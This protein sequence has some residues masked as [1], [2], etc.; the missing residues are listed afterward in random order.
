MTTN[1]CLDQIRKRRPQAEEGELASLAAAGHSPEEQFEESEKQGRLARL[2]ARL[3]ERER[4]CLMLRDLE[5][6][7]SREVE[8]MLECSEETL[9]SAIHR[10]KEK[11]SK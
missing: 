1:L 7:N 9:R 5:G 8:A 3:P 6:L 11:P 10:A 4:A 2:I